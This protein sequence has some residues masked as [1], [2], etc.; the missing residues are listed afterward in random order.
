MC[1]LC[2][3]IIGDLKKRRVK[4]IEALTDT[5]TRLLLLSEHRGPYATGIAWVKRD[6]SMLV[7]KEPLPARTFVQSGAFLDW[8]L[9]VDRQV[10][11]LMGHTR[12]PS[13]G[14]VRNPAENHPICTP[15]ILL[16]HNGT[17]YEHAHHFSRLHLRRT[18][19][20]DSELLARIAQHHTGI[21]GV[22]ITSYLDALAPLDGSMSVALA[23]TTRPDEIILLKGNMP[24]EVRL[25]RKKRVVLYASEARILDVAL[26]GETGW[27]VI[28][29][30]PGEA[31]VFNTAAIHAPQRRVFT[32]SGMAVAR[33][34]LSVTG[35][36]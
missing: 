28:P 15:P 18:T 21:A 13:R 19:Q 27:E 8:L 11:Y 9:G 29:V 34:R 25:H 14:N 32:F 6:R 2:G 1:G 10:T 17:I 5:F 31:L 30:L 23:A 36:A 26:D 7:A 16:C 4:D 33:T 22:D 3:A 35:L 12:W 24:L 20:V